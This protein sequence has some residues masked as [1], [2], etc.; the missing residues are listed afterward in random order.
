MINNVNGSSEIDWYPNALVSCQVLKVLGCWFALDII[1]GFTLNILVITI[2]LRNKDLHSTTNAFIVSISVCDLVASVIEMPLP[3]VASFMC[4]WPFGKLVCYFEAFTVYFCGCASMYLLTFV[5]I[6]RFISISLPFEHQRLTKNFQ[7]GCIAIS[8]LIALFWS[9]VP[10]F[11]WS[12]YTLEGAL[13][14][15]AITWQ[16]KSPNV[17]TYN[18]FIFIFVFFLPICIMITCNLKLYLTVILS[19]SSFTQKFNKF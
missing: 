15:C 3:M 11:G 9:I 18:V 1:A 17:V 19:S 16:D 6:D 13:I 10:L 5:S 2:Y 4:K 8:L 14:S 7:R 12:S